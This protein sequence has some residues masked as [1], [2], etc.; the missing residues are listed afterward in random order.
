MQGVVVSHHS[1]F[2]I[3]F[4]IR[5]VAL[6]ALTLSIVMTRCGETC[7]GQGAKSAD[8]PAASQSDANDKVLRHAVFFQFKSTATK[9]DVDRV[10]QLF[11]ELPSKIKEIREFQS[12]ENLSRGGFSNGLTYCFLLTFDDEAGRAA[13]LPHKDHKAFGAALGP[14]LEQVFVIDYWGRRQEKPLEKQLKHAVFLRF[15]ENA[16]DADKKTIEDGL[17]GLPEKVDAIKAFE[18]GTNNSPESHDQGFTHCFMYT[19]DSQDGLRQYGAHPSHLE[20]ARKLRPAV[21][22]ARV[23]DF[24]A[25]EAPVQDA[26]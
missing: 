8:T 24:W 7:Y 23:L 6:V 18:W 20:V 25:E 2:T 13:Y 1:R 21:E 3:R 26:R 19:F 4:P 12:G 15:S 16:T 17:A 11:R 14:H 10:V 22:R 9:A 5:S